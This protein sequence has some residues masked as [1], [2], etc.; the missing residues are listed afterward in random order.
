MSK[1]IILVQLT[2]FQTDTFLSLC[3]VKLVCLTELMVGDCIAQYFLKL[4]AYIYSPDRIKILWIHLNC[5]R[6]VVF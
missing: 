6:R 4:T 1:T 5:Y 2:F 3:E